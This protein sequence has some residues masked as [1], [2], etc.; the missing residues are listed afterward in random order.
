MNEWER[1]HKQAIQIQREYPPGVKIELL[2]MVDDPRPITANTKGTVLK[3]D[4]IGTIHCAFE[5][6][7]LL[8]IIPGKDSFRKVICKDT[9]KE[10]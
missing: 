9:E 4:D 10:L 7:R 6:G 8:G 5:N 3:V 2:E 1:L